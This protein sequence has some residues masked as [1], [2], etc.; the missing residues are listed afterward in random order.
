MR[1]GETLDYIAYQHYGDAAQWRHI[2]QANN[3]LNPK[4]LRPGLVLKLT[5]LPEGV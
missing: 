4:N 5:P 1:A 2:A 3:L